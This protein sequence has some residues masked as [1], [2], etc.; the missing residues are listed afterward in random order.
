MG[1]LSPSLFTRLIIL[2]TMG[3]AIA[4]DVT[5]A[6]AASIK[7]YKDFLGKSGR[8]D[9]HTPNG[10]GGDDRSREGYKFNRSLLIQSLDLSTEDS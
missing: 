7:R 4:D 8:I 9:S 2:L 3:F 10:S 1:I 5:K 6:N